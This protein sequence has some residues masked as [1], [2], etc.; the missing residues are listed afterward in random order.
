MRYIVA[1]S[2]G[3][4]SQACLLWAREHLPNFEVVFCDTKWEHPIV[5]EH[6]AYQQDFIS[7]EF[8][9]LVSD[10]YDG[11]VDLC[12]KKKRVASLKSRF[13][14]E[15]LKV[16]PMID[17]IL[18]IQDDV[19]VIQGVRND[20]SASRATLKEKD[21]Y[22]KFYF[23]PYG[24][25]KKGK[26][27]FHTYRKKEVITHCDKFTVDVWRPIIKWTAQDV[28]AYSIERKMKLNPLYFNGM[29]RVGCFPCVMCNHTEIRLIAERFPERIDLIRKLEQAIGRTFFPPDY[30]PDRFCDMQVTAKS[31][32]VVKVATIDAVV[33]YVT[34]GV[35]SA[36]GLFGKQTGCISV[37]NI[38]EL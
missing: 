3:K 7:K 36:N 31:G 35:N 22:F 9:T 28:I 4:D 10:K 17:Y 2:G 8:K 25:D 15:E 20:E 21:E 30:I 24:Y 12:I 1:N 33:A 32:K 23:E 13:C 18:S 19:T 34:K 38:C 11:F 16:K 5:Y 14:T 37:Y 26:P 6:L 27:K 29:G